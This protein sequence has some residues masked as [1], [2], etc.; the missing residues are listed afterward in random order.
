MAE[1][2]RKRDETDAATTQREQRKR[3]TPSSA[4]STFIQ[5]VT[6]PAEDEETVGNRSILGVG[7]GMVVWYPE[8]C[9]FFMLTL[10]NFLKIIRLFY[11]QV[12]TPWRLNPESAAGRW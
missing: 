1:L 9:S 6:L 3:V 7:G 5:N 12:G 10:I 4:V 11:L 2:K 8:T